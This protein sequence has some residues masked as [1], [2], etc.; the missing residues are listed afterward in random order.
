MAEGLKPHHHQYFEYDC[1]SHFDSR[2]HVIVKKVTYMCMICG[3]LSHETYEE[4]CL[5]PK[6]R[7]PKALMKYRSRQKSG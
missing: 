1:K 5:P 2:R 6:E 7:K 3:K 4:Y